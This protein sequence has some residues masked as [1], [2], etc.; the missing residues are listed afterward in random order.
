MVEQRG[1]ELACAILDIWMPGAN[2]IDAAHVIQQLAPDL[3]IMLVSG[4]LPNIAAGK[5]SGLRLAGM[6]EKPFSIAGLRSMIRLAVPNR[7]ARE[8]QFRT[9]IPEFEDR[10][11]FS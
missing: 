4:A 7:R 8:I 10:S 5:L 6:L 2:G 1:S 11:D 9:T 3:P